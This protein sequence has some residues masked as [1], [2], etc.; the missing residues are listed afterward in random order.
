[1]KPSNS[2]QTSSKQN[3]PITSEILPPQS[4][5]NNSSSLS[6]EAIKP[7]SLHQAQELIH[8]NANDNLQR[9]QV[10]ANSKKIVEA[11]EYNLS[12][13]IALPKEIQYTI[14]SNLDQKSLEKFFLSLE[15]HIRL[16]L[17]KISSHQPLSKHEE[18]YIQLLEV[19]LMSFSQPLDCNATVCKILE[20]AQKLGFKKLFE[21]SPLLSIDF[22]SP[23]PDTFS[24]AALKKILK[25][26]ASGFKTV[27]LKNRKENAIIFSTKPF[28]GL[29]TLRVK[30]S[31][32]L[33][34]FELDDQ[35]N[36]IK[37]IE[38]LNCKNLKTVDIQDGFQ[39]EAFICKNAVNLETIKP[40]ANGSIHS[41]KLVDCCLDKINLKHLAAGLQNS[42]HNLDL[43]ECTIENITCLIDF[44]SALK[45][46]Q[47][48]NLH[49]LPII[50]CN[51]LNQLSHLEKIDLSCLLDAFNLNL[52]LN[53]AN[54]KKLKSINLSGRTITD[55]SFLSSLSSLEQVGLAYVNLG[56][57][58]VLQT[59]GSLKKL[60]LLDI[61]GND[62]ITHLNFLNSLSQLETLHI[63]G[64]EGI[65]ADEF[66]NLN[67]LHKLKKLSLGINSQITDFSFLEPLI[68]LEELSLEGYSPISPESF[69]SLKN[70]EN[71]KKLNLNNTNIQD[72]SF[73][74][75][76]RSLQ[77]LNIKY[78]SLLD[79][80]AIEQVA[81]D[82]PGCTITKE[83][84]IETASEE[85]I[86]WSEDEWSENED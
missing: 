81:N 20:C 18:T 14:F 36:T 4:Y 67:A 40:S 21:Q 57:E 85:E 61:S 45:D 51:F 52:S 5:A 11:C 53:L 41:F 63:D 83:E 69:A 7:P 86:F 23:L 65:P 35:H 60:K 25:G 31:T 42:C 82:L 3:L 70:L 77:E 68:E 75:S 1:M 39:L 10:Q 50:D 73:L 71:L 26:T 56:N 64:C 8:G 27:A 32:T 12:K 17:S 34:S 72:L 9:R 80:S 29:E 47:V 48:L 6:H 78:C 24:Y 55:L 58:G 74:K 38:L 54:L 44:I 84:P 30:P 59:L 43:A 62:Q 22:N 37:T 79:Q 19:A 28:P 2:H 46:L 76:L 15:K 33:Q 13:L 49:D 16:S 66:I